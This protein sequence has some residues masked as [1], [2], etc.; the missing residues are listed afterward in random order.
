MAKKI[1]SRSYLM[2]ITAA[3]IAIAIAVASFVYSLVKDSGGYPGVEFT[4]SE[5]DTV[6]VNPSG[7]SF[8]DHAPDIEPPTTKPPVN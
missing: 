7:G 2:G 3:L 5:N 4:V 6:S 1:Y 8:P